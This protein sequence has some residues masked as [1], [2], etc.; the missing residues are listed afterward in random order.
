MYNDLK[1][2]MKRIIIICEDPTEVEFCK[3]ILA[4]Y[5]LSKEIFLQTPLIKKSGGGIVNWGVLKQQITAHLYEQ[6][7]IVTTLIDYYGI[8]EKHKFPKWEAAKKRVK[9]DERMDFLEKAMK[10]DF[11]DA[12]KYRFFPYLQLHEFEGLLFNNIAAFDKEL[13]PDEFDRAAL[14]KVIDDY[15]NPE[16]INDNSKTAPS[17]RLENLIKGYN[18][19]VYGCIIA[20]NIGLSKMRK[21]S[22]RFNHW[23]TILENL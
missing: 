1:K 4:P 16:L 10:E 23:I 13:E 17:K 18:K 8:N 9:K 15:P 5:F 7:V 19:I 12:L 6:E 2:T 3:T 22:P 20:E 11:G 14:K 21:K